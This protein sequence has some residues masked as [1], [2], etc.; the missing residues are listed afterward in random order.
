MHVIQWNGVDVPAELRELPPGMYVVE[1][2]DEGVVS[3]KTS[4]NVSTG[5]VMDSLQSKL[6]RPIELADLVDVETVTRLANSVE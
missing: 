1:R 2:V 5:H 6:G 3:T 4:D